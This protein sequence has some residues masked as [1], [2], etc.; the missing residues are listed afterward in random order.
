MTTRTYPRTV[1]V[2]TPSFNIKAVEVVKQYGSR[3][4]DYGDLT[5]AGKCYAVCDMHDSFDAAVADGRAQIEKQGEDLRK[6]MSSLLK[7]KAA[8]TKAEKKGAAK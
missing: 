8:L 1:W 7:R 2:L 4:T 3:Y 5:A 6:R